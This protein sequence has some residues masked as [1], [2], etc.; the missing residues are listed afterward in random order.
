[1]FPCI[2]TNAE[3]A[4]PYNLR[5]WLDIYYVPDYLLYHVLKLLPT[6]SP[7]KICSFFS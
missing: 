3:H 6:L 7:A 4:T 5:E 1:M 2:G